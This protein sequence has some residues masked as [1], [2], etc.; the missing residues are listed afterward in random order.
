MATAMESVQNKTD[1][2]LSVNDIQFKQKTNETLLQ[3]SNDQTTDEEQKTKD[4]GFMEVP[5]NTTQKEEREKKLPKRI[6]HFS[7]GILEEY[8]TDEEEAQDETDSTALL[9]T[10]QMAW[11][12][13]LWYMTWWIG[14]RTLAGCDFVGEKLAHFFGI[15]TP[16]YQYELEEYQR[17]LKEEEEE[18]EKTAEENVGWKQE[19][20]QLRSVEVEPSVKTSL[21]SIQSPSGSVGDSEVVTPDVLSLSDEKIQMATSDTVLQQHVNVPDV[22]ASQLRDD[23]STITLETES[24]LT[25]IG[26]ITKSSAPSLEPH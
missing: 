25:M 18:K 24:D 1:I 26:N 20:D 5:L 2:T 14:C 6:L 7:D 12:P 8:S 23:T 3:I 4:P 15:T 11:M 21:E 22:A 19:T 13:Y 10:K 16:K 17:M 9:D